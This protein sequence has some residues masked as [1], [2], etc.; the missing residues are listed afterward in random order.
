MSIEKL[1]PYADF[2]FENGALEK[3][4]FPF[5]QLLNKPIQELGSLELIG[6]WAYLQSLPPNWHINFVH[7]KCA[8]HIGKNKLYRLFAQLIDHNLISKIT[9][10]NED[11]TYKSTHYKVLNGTNFKLAHPLPGNPD[12]DNPEVDNE[13]PINKTK[14]Q[15]IQK[16]EIKHSCASDD[17][18]SNI[19]QSR[20]DDF[21]KIYPRK[22]NKNRARDIW[23]SKKLDK[24][25]DMIIS[26]VKNRVLNDSDWQEEKYTLHASTYLQNKR[27]EDEIT[28]RKSKPEKESHFE[29][30]KR[31]FSETDHNERNQYN[32]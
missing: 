15:T 11:G 21:W 12:V 2:H 6:L 18:R 30:M 1:N 32:D 9:E 24:M 19:E 5:T 25:A 13:T 23:K 7:L 27:W 10:K 31:A 8:L 3:E 14:T 20:F 22:K 26:D 16:T 4:P 29:M 17:A 28:L